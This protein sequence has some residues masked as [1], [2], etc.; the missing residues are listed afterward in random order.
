V[1]ATGTA[2]A[3]VAVWRAAAPVLAAAAFLLAALLC[4]SGCSWP[5][6]VDGATDR[7]VLEYRIDTSD[8]TPEQ[9]DA[10]RLGMAFWAA[11]LPGADL[12]ELDAPA[13]GCQPGG[14][15]DSRHCFVSLPVG[16]EVFEL[17]PGES[18]TGAP[19]VGRQFR[20][21]TAI[22]ADV[23]ADPTN[24]MAGAYLMALV[25]AHEFGHRI[26]LEH[27]DEGLMAAVATP[28]TAWILSPK[29]VRLLES[30]GW[31]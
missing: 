8:F 23:G 16:H 19:C 14:F 9:A 17:Q 20:G 1:S 4:G 21:W 24:D 18:S 27:T 3:A 30:R 29:A 2:A 11:E 22:R 6:P 31:R 13:G 15:G 7:S 12:V 10:I 28:A 5:S 26:G 25:A